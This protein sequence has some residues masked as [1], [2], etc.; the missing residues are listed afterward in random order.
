MKTCSELLIQ[1]YWH[2]CRNHESSSHDSAMI[3]K[4]P[5]PYAIGYNL[6][7]PSLHYYPAAGNSKHCWYLADIYYHWWDLLLMINLNRVLH[8]PITWKRDQ[9]SSSTT[10]HGPWIILSHAMIREQPHR[11]LL[12]AFFTTMLLKRQE[13]HWTTE[14]DLS[15]IGLIQRG[16]HIATVG[17]WLTGSDCIT[18][19]I[20]HTPCT[21]LYTLGSNSILLITVK[22]LSATRTDTF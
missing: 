15:C 8:Q 17:A 5:H 20:Q 13:H 11:S 6:W 9:H 10:L 7:P 2:T 18:S 21:K 12:D 1:A 16:K 14:L 3:S 4:Q 22:A 19:C